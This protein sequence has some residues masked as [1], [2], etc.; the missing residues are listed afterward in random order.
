M[1]MLSTQKTKS[2]IQPGAILGMR[3]F[4]RTTPA[5]FL[6][7]D[8][9]M[10]RIPL[11]QGKFALVDD[12]DYDWLNQWKWCARKSPYTWYALR[13]I[14]CNG[15][16]KTILMHREILGLKPGDKRQ[17]DHRN[18][19]GLANWRDNLRAC[20]RTQN[21]RNRNVQKNCAS[22]FKGVYWSKC[23]RKWQVQIQING[24]KSHLGFFISKIEAAKAY[25]KAAIKY[26]GEFANTN[27]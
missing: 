16:V 2:R 3:P 27:F 26:F 21:Q 11:T 7:G 25:D 10:K 23:S 17:T 22:E 12:A 20:T 9:Q 19:N 24:K 8:C 13:S 18:H 6:F 4:L 1:K 15:K 14:Y 5:G